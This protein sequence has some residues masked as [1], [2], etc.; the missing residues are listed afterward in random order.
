[1]AL[2]LRLLP[3]TGQVRRFADDLLTADIVPASE[4]ADALHVAFAAVH[5]MDY[6]LT[7]NYAHLANEHVQ[8]RLDRLCRD[9]NLQSPLVVT[10]DTIPRVSLGQTIRRSK[11][12]P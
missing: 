3:N 7:W 10:P 12:W 1:M 4:P 9:V 2:R 6:L 8:R 5:Q 11:E